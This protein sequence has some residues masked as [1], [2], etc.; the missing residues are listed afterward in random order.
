MSIIACFLLTAVAGAC[1]VAFFDQVRCFG[2]GPDFF[3][4]MTVIAAVHLDTGAAVAI[5]ILSGLFKDIFC[6]VPLG[7]NAAI[8]P[9]LAITVSRLNRTLSL[10]NRLACAL[11]SGVAVVAA[12]CAAWIILSYSQL[13]VPHGAF[14]RAIFFEALLT[15]AVTP[16][17]FAVS[18]LHIRTAQ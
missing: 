1:Q 7:V 9:F 18:R 14:L 15:A 12:D 13:S 17:L 4:A 3:L 16:L 2:A 6:A 5:G 11:I 8:L 10:E